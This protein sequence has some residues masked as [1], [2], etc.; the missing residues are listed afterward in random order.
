MPPQPK[1]KAQPAEPF[2]P[3]E[4]RR[5]ATRLKPH[6]VPWIREVKPISGD[7]AR[8]LNISKTGVLLETTARLQPGRR[9]TVVIVDGQDQKERAEGHVIRTELVS[10]GPAGELIYRTAMA[11]AEELDLR[12]PEVIREPV[13]ATLDPSADVSVEGPLH[14]M[15]TTTSGSQRVTVTH[16]SQ[17]GCYVQSAQQVAVEDWATLTVFFSPLRSLT[18]SGTVAAV[19]ENRG[20][21]VRFDDLSPETR[22]GLRV[23]IRESLAA[24]GPSVA[25]PPVS[26]GL[27]TE[28]VDQGDVV[29]EWQTDASSLH[30]NQW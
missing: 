16:V 12:L 11:F 9:S 21:L 10:I 13:V 2:V 1:I 26:I 27:I 24:Q 19:E 4:D 18:L 29:V 23:E 5:I 30:A 22:R 6:E 8:L 17:S 7:R 3:A 20:C 28:N 25:P 14:A 15:C